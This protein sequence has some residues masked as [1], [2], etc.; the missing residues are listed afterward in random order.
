MPRNGANAIKRKGELTAIEACSALDVGYDKLRRL[1]A[2]TRRGYPRLRG[3]KRS[4]VIL[5]KRTEVERFERF[6]ER[7][8]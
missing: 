1:L 7:Y 5:I 4:G 2:E 6:M 3:T 8:V